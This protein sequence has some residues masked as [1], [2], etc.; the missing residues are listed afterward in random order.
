MA[1]HPGG[2]SVKSFYRT[3]P[4]FSSYQG[5]AQVNADQFIDQRTRLI[6]LKRIDNYPLVAVAAIDENNSVASYAVTQLVY[7]GIAGGFSA[8]ILLLAAGGA[9]TQLKHLERL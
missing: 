2:G 6:S 5:N 4:S 8:L 1:S 3:P 9:Y 7:L